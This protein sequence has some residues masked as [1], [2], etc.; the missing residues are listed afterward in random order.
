MITSMHF[1]DNLEVDEDIDSEKVI[2]LVNN[3][4][5]VWIDVVSEP[6]RSVSD[7]LKSIFPEYHSLILE[8]MFENTRPKLEVYDG[9][10]FLV[11]KTFPFG[12]FRTSQI[13]VVLG[14]T[15][16]LTIRDSSSDLSKVVDILRAG[17]SKTP[18][19]VLYKILESVFGNYYH[20]LES[21]DSK[22]DR[23]E[24]ESLKKPKQSTLTHI[25]DLKKKLVKMHKILLSEREIVLSLSRGNVNL[26]RQRTAVF[27]RDTYDDV[28][29]LID[30]EETYREALSGNIEIYMSSVNN[31]MNE[32]MK[33]LTIIASFTFV[34]AL[35]A[36]FYGMNIEGMPFQELVY[37]GYDYAYLFVLGLMCIAVGY[38][39]VVFKKREWL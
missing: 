21:V 27:M 26:I 31:S 33:T 12:S 1:N 38:L 19:F 22:T 8:D 32:I 17:K 37:N 34:P 4:N 35:I 7:I 16:L 11:L 2:R 14:K 28:V 39:Y 23:F 13:N 36:G 3:P 9:F 29:A 10:M 30:M 25:L 24:S 18:D 15:F 6:K 20:V 5:N